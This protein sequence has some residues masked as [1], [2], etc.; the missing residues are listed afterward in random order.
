[1]GSIQ[2]RVTRELDQTR[3][4]QC[5]AAC[6]EVHA[7][8]LDINAT[9]TLQT[10]THSTR[11]RLGSA[12][13]QA[14]VSSSGGPWGLHAQRSLTARIYTNPGCGLLIGRPLGS[15]SRLLPQGH[16]V[17]Q[18]ARFACPEAAPFVGRETLEGKNELSSCAPRACCGLSGVS[19][20]V[21][22][23]HDIKNASSQ[24]LSARVR[25]S[26][27]CVIISRRCP[28]CK[29]ETFLRK[30]QLFPAPPLQAP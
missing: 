12:Q 26:H 27:C 21:V 5:A 9:L 10:H 2:N 17:P 24:F 28:S 30:Q 29:T 11:S 13:T 25:R 15:P 18:A 7:V 16:M 4:L 6:P 19:L 23:M 3:G 8:P 1:M 20:M 14:V 22:K